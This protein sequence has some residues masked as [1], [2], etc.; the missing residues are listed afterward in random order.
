M[1]RGSCDFWWW[2]K[3]KSYIGKGNISKSGLPVLVYNVKLVKGLSAN[4]ISVSQL[5]DQGFT[6]TFT[7]DTYKVLNQD[8]SIVMMSTWLWDSCYHWDNYLKNYV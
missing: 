4:L 7:K 5:C 2:S 6:I 3:R 1:Q 8:K